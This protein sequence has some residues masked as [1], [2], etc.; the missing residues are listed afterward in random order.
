MWGDDE[1]VV[2]AVGEVRRF[3]VFTGRF[4]LFAATGGRGIGVAHFG[5]DGILF[6]GL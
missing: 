4:W 2:V 1:D 5:L 6:A 3:S